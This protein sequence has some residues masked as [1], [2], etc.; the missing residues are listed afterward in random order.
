MSPAEI[1]RDFQRKYEGTY[2]FVKTPDSNEENLFRMDKVTPSDTCTGLLSLSSEEYGK[3]QL[4]Y[5]TAH[6]II[7][8]FP[9]VGVFQHGEESYYFNR[10]PARQYRRGL[11]QDNGSIHAVMGH[12]T[13]HSH[14]EAMT[15][16]LVVS[17]FEHRTYGFSE[18][19]KLVGNKVKGCALDNN[20]SLVLSMTKSAHFYLMWYRHPVALLKE[21][22]ELIAVLS[23]QFETA[24][25]QVMST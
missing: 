22:G 19:I 18:A 23:N 10:V 11:C 15:F 20:F 17:A 8:K 1:L 5:G 7:C 16:P 12:V 14:A 21:T 13:G 4:N 9:Q 6:T 3:I 2:M 24:I 25:K